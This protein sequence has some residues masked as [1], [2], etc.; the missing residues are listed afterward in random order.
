MI[1]K[2]A[3]YLT[4]KK[5][6]CSYGYRQAACNVQY[7]DTLKIKWLSAQPKQNHGFSNLII[8]LT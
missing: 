7:P 8:N 6:Y 5:D 1:F 4:F 2:I 3:A